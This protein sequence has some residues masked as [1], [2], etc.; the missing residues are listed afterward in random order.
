[1]TPKSILITL[2]LTIAAMAIVNRVGFL[3]DIVD[4]A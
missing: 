3:R 1:M 4:P 2:A